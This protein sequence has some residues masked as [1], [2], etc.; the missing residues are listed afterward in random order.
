MIRAAIADNFNYG[1]HLRFVSSDALLNDPSMCVYHV[2]S[3]EISSS[4]VDG[5]AGT[6]VCSINLA[7]ANVEALAY[8]HLRGIV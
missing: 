2:R 1:G 3:F 5:R 4:I 6:T 8:G 7:E